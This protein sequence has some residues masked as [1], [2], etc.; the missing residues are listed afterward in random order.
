VR[1]NFYLFSINIYWVYKLIFQ[2]IFINFLM[3][4][5]LLAI[6]KNN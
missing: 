6:R 2:F 1:F 3:N 5:R 4:L